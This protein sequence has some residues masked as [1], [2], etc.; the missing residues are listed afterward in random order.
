MGNPVGSFTKPIR[1]AGGLRDGDTGDE[2]C[3]QPEG[4]AARIAAGGL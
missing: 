1:V 3:C 2:N 4:E